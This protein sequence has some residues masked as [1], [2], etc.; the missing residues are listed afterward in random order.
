MKANEIVRSAV[1]RAGRAA[2][3]SSAILLIGATEALGQ[4]TA[5]TLDDAV[6]IALQQNTTIKQAQNAV[7]LQGAAVQQQKLSFLPDFRASVSGSGNLG[8]TVNEGQIVTQTSHAL[9]TGLSS[10]VTLFD[11]FKNVSSL[12]SAKLSEDASAKDLSRTK[13]TVVFNVASN[14]LALVVQ[15]EQVKV[16]EKTLGALTTQRDQID[17]FVKAGAR[18]VSDLYQ[19]EASVAGT[20]ASL[21][22]AQRALE[23]AKVDLIQTL[24][25]DPSGDYS[26]VTPVVNDSAAVGKTYNLDQL[27]ATAYARRIDLKAGEMR[28]DAMGQDVRASQAGMW[29]TISLITGYNT[30]FN[31]ANDLGLADQLD[32]RR[33]G[34]VGI[35]VSIPIFDRGATGLAAQ[36][37][38]IQEDNAQL[39][40]QIQKQ[41]VALQVRRAFLDEKAAQERLIAAKAQQA[42]AD[43][44]VNALRERYRVGA[45]TFVEL[46]Q[47]QASQATAESALVNAKYNLVFQQK[48][49]S[50]Y[51]GELDPSIGFGS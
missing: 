7:T 21:V 35:G 18:P 37:A 2:V 8:R 1:G 9:N 19:Q 34:S 26:F 46:T 30:S 32:Q 38:E 4:A 45:S 24:Q 15:H 28:V 23:L 49:M 29:P 10:S 3:I 39:A 47:A 22:D 5:I 42:A 50:Y 43:Q 48:L 17:K 12:R 13:Q 51:T 27:L 6:G 31:S 40:L 25:L 41:D 44:A 20:K 33:G 36:R 14:F 16:Q 11:G